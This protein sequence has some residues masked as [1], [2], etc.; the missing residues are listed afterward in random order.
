MILPG[1]TVGVL[2]GGQLGR[3]FVFRAHE[4][5]Y[6]V[7]VLDPDTKSPAGLVADEHL[8]AA[9][10]DETALRALAS[11]CAAVTTEFENVPAGTLA[12]L[13]SLTSVSPSSVAVAIA[14]DRILEKTHLADAGFQTAAFLPVRSLNEAGEAFERMGRPAILKTSR[15]G[16]DGKGQA[17]VTSADACTAAFER[18][19]RQECILEEKLGLDLE[20]SVII[21]RS[22][23]GETAVYPPG[24]NVHHNGILYSSVVPARIPDA[25]AREARAMA[26][27]ITGSLEYVG[28]MGVELFV[29]NGGKLYVNEIAPRPHNSGHY[30]IDAAATDQFEQQ[31]RAMCGLPLGST[32]LLSP[33]AM[34]NLLGDLWASG[35]PRWARALEVP[36]VRLHLYGK[37]EA[38][39]GR[40][41]GHLT[42][43]A[44]SAEEALKGAE[45]AAGR[46]DGSAA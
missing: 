29:A 42:C 35:E 9:Y 13:T 16:Y 28:V 7:V 21:A 4:M 18:L 24:E 41:M 36:G 22:A 34:I 17:V 30:S 10:D 19:G 8:Q 15:L 33:V 11:R 5:G 23:K 31:L 6:R 43:V 26:E 32:R 27:E 14:Q 20:V 39:P 3:M 1:A 46:L 25:L 45:M 38:R 12:L 44:S 2:G 37:A 40:K